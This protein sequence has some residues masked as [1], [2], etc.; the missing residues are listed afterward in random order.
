MEGL[1]SRDALSKKQISW[2]RDIS[3]QSSSPIEKTDKRSSLFDKSAS[4]DTTIDKIDQ[5]SSSQIE[6]SSKLNELNTKIADSIN[7]LNLL[8]N[9][10][11]SLKDNKP[12]HIV[13]SVLKNDAVMSSVIEDNY[14]PIL[15]MNFTIQLPDVDESTF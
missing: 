4:L 11:Q 2:M 14:K 9:E 3:T 13:Q 10:V 12:N 1:R 5:L 7:L 15:P 8:Y 6:V